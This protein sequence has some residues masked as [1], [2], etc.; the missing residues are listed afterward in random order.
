MFINNKVVL[1]CLF[2]AIAMALSV[3]SNVLVKKTM[4]NF[5]LPAWE[6]IAIRQAIIVV[7]L[8][9]FMIKKKFNFFRKD[10]LGINLIRNVLYAI[11][12]GLAH[13]AFLYIPIN[14]G[15][16]LQFFA[17]VMTSVFAIFLLKEKNILSI[18]VA[19]ILCF[20]G[21]LFIQPP[22][23]GSASVK[24]AYILFAISIILKSLNGILNRILALKFDTYTLVFY[25]HI[26]I[27]LVSLCFFRSFKVAPMQAILIL[28]VV[29][30][31]YLLEYILIYI[32]QKHCTV[33]ILQPLDFSK[34]IY[35][36]ILSNLILGE[37][38]TIRQ[39]IGG[40]II[41]FGCAVMMFGKQYK[42]NQTIK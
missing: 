11:S 3:S 30:I 31:I 22:S 19:L 5:N 20:C 14:E 27:L 8:L 7:I 9:P 39:I 29:G 18:W 2:Y 21:A 1:G 40:S 34:I 26:I 12:I 33:T 41:L 13:I 28:G 6:S 15:T 25:M 16:S 23:I 35:S 36:I 37:T 32:A 10:A 4:I 38:L 42:N 17:P 24:T